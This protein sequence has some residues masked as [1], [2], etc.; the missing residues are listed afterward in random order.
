MST[1]ADPLDEATDDNPADL[2][3]PSATPPEHEF[4]PYALPPEEIEE[5]PTRLLDAI[6][7]IGPGLILAASI[8]GTGE[9]INTTG[10]GAKAG[11]ALLWLILLSCVIKVFVQVELG[12][13]AITHGKTSLAAFDTLPGPRLGAGWMCWLF[14]LMTIMTQAQIAAMEGTVGQ[15]AHMAFPGASNAVAHAF[16]SVNPTWGAFLST[17]QEYFWAALTT[18]AAV[19][20]L[21]SGGYRRLEHVTTV[22]VGLVTFFTV[23]SVALLQWTPFRIRMENFGEGFNFAIPTAAVALGFSAFGITGVGAS[24]LFAYPYWCI[25]KGYAR[26]AGKQSNDPD[27]VRRA[28]GWINVMKL[29]AWFSMIVF[30]VAT[31]SFYLLGAAVLHP[32]DLD[33]KGPEMIPTL[34]KMYLQP[35]EQTPLKALRGVTRVGFLLGAW[36]VLFK[37]LYVATAANSRL[38]ADFLNLSGIWRQKMPHNRDHTVR[39]FCVIYPMTA[40]ACYYALR[41]PQ[42]LIKIGGVS[43]GLLL[44]LIAG[45][46]L[47]L[48]RR[49]FDR[50]V[51]PTFLA[52]I[53]TWLAFFLITAV[54]SYSVWDLAR[55]N[56]QY[57]T[58]ARWLG[59]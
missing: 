6:K 44:P 30:T 27:W 16:G 38:T 23:A 8:V 57:F 56:F 13:Y 29:D 54:A 58:P 11:F 25:E 43:Q 9:L 12:R 2:A 50:R 1:A 47:Y 15:A 51:G 10:L 7:M 41:E 24:E 18:L 53:F 19:V 39:F 59:F 17:R 26:K 40:L 37:T 3:A 48:G 5:P 42:F 32:Q 49:D 14:I 20:L 33:P 52:D 28:N 45:G 4:D 34:S 31:V 46:T 36:A 35:L 21:L 55:N 22:L